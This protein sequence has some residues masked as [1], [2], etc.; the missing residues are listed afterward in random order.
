MNLKSIN[1]ASWIFTHRFYFIVL[2]ILLFVIYYKLQISFLVAPRILK[3]PK[4]T[5]D[6]YEAD[7]KEET[8]RKL[9][10]LY[11][12]IAAF[13]DRNEMKKISEDDE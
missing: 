5:L 7:K 2:I 12:K 10:E 3:T 11:P 9:N 1:M 8:N 6:Q 13:Y 4:K